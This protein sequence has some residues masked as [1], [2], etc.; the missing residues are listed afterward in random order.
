MNVA[1]A[2]AQRRDVLGRHDIVVDDQRRE[3]ALRK[4]V[5]GLDGAVTRRCR[6]GKRTAELVAEQGQG[7]IGR[8]ETFRRHML[9]GF[10][11]LAVV[12]DVR[13]RQPRFADTARSVDGDGALALIGERGGIAFN[14]NGAKLL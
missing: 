11:N 5:E 12:V 4:G 1:G 14:Q 3:F 2:D 7:F 8:A 13:A 9:D 6:F 10:V